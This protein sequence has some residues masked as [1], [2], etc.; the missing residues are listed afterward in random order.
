M[1]SKGCEVGTA[2]ESQS[3]KGTTKTLVHSSVIRLFELFNQ[4]E[5][6]AGR[7]HF[8]PDTA[9]KQLRFNMCVLKSRGTK[10]HHAGRLQYIAMLEVTVEFK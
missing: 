1:G 2:F 4:Q 7:R 8:L 6:A 9:G 5:G 3:L 10:T